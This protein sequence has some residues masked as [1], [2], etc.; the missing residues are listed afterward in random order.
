MNRLRFCRF[1]SS[2]TLGVNFLVSFELNVDGHNEAT[3]SFSRETFDQLK[4]YTLGICFE[5]VSA[6]SLVCEIYS[7]K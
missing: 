4:L 7:T 2:L 5:L 3:R 1:I 6:F